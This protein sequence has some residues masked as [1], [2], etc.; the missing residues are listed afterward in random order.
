VTPP[1]R[2]GRGRFVDLAAAAPLI[3]FFAFAI[4]GFALRIRG[5]VAQQPHSGQLAL[6]VATQTAGAVFAGLQVVFLIIRKLP[7][8]KYGTWWPRVIA[9]VGGNS[10]LLF[11]LL[12]AAAPRPGVNLLSSL[13]VIAGTLG[14]ILA[15]SRLGRSFSVT[16]QARALVVSGPYR[17]VRHPLFLAELII[18]LG[19]ML[20]YRQPWAFLV[21]AASAGAMIPRMH[22][23]ELILSRTFPA[24]PAYA[25][26]TARLIPGLY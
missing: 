5:A 16:P 19:V 8:A 12:P 20:Q 25:A 23:E 22:F 11:L 4:T 2:P 17:I 26:R 24:Y 1:R 21:L 6:S 7:V 18:I 10:P 14:S 13:L 15:L 3:I 9:A